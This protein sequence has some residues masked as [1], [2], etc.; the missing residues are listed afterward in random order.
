[1]PASALQSLRSALETLRSL[2]RRARESGSLERAE[3]Y[4][5]LAGRYEAEIAR[6]EHE[7]APGSVPEPGGSER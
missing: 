1:M 6:L 4:A 5:N 2:E 3:S 7:S